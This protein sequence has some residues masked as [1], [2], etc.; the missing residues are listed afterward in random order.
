[1]AMADTVAIPAEALDRK[2]AEYVVPKDSPTITPGLRLV[3][4]AFDGYGLHMAPDSVEWIKVEGV[5]AVEIINSGPI[6][7]TVGIVS[8][9]EGASGK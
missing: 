9:L 5:G 2:D 7:V 3:I 1:M 4:N 8:L 6:G